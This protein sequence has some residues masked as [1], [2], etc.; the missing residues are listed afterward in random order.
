MDK[1]K[2]GSFSFHTQPKVKAACMQDNMLQ[3]YLCQPQRDVPACSVCCH[4]RPGATG[5]DSASKH[6]GKMCPG[7]LLLRRLQASSC[8]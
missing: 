6:S 2:K 7:C 5:A 4:T 1:K 8:C 3:A